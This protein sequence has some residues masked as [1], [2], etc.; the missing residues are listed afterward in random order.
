MKN[1]NEDASNRMATISEF[2]AE[3]NFLT[4]D[5][6]DGNLKYDQQIEY[7]EQINEWIHQIGRL[8]GYDIDTRVSTVKVVMQLKFRLGCISR[9]YR[10]SYSRV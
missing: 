1:I 8:T 2:A 9:G 5:N 3:I 6:V 10:G 4:M 7:R